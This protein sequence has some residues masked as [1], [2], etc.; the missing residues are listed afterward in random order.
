MHFIRTAFAHIFRTFRSALTLEHFKRFQDGHYKNDGI[1]SS[2]WFVLTI[3]CL[4]LSSCTTPGCSSGVCVKVTAA[5]P[6]IYK[7]ED[8]PV[9]LT[10]TVTSDK[11]Q[12]IYISLETSATAEFREVNEGSFPYISILDKRLVT[13]YPIETKANMPVSLSMFVVLPEEG[14]YLI[15]A[16]AGAKNVDWGRASYSIRI[17]YFDSGSKIYLPGT[18]IVST[19]RPLP[20]YHGPTLTVGP[21]PTYPPPPTLR[22]IPTKTI[23]RLP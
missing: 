4:C 13:W 21:T 7:N 12:E 8:V 6:I 16:N 3:I 23:T 19:P 17:E 11:D 10:L 20:A 5:E 22:P 9:L 2:L 18:R 1:K 15:V 14:Y